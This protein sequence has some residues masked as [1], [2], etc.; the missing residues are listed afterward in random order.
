VDDRLPRTFLYLPPRH[1]LPRAEPK[2]GLSSSRRGVLKG[3]FRDETEAALERARVL[4]RELESLEASNQDKQSTIDQLAQQLEAQRVEIEHLRAAA[5]L[6]HELHGRPRRRRR[7]D[8]DPT[9]RRG[10]RDS[11][12][13]RQH[14]RRD[15]NGLHTAVEPRRDPRSR[16]R[17]F[18]LLI[19]VGALVALAAA[20][21]LLTASC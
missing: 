12:A 9:I 11:D 19:A 10:R 16:R 1:L 8:S 13:Q 6:E 17:I 7:K 18:V 5:T 2:P 4:E 15:S 21:A 14:P 3:M 20:L